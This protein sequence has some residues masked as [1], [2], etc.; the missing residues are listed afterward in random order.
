MAGNE[1]PPEKSAGDHI[2]EAAQTVATAAKAAADFAAGNYLGAA[3]EAAKLLP[4]LLKL[5]AVIVGIFFALQLMLCAIIAMMASTG[6]VMKYVYSGY[7]DAELMND[8]EWDITKQY[9]DDF[10]PQIMSMYKKA[11]YKECNRI[12]SF[13]KTNICDNV[14]AAADALFSAAEEGALITDYK[15]D[16]AYK[17]MFGD[18]FNNPLD[19]TDDSYYEIKNAALN[20]TCMYN[21]WNATLDNWDDVYPDDSMLDF[22]KTE[23][24][25]TDVTTLMSW[26]ADTFSSVRAFADLGITV[27]KGLIDANKVTIDQIVDPE[28]Y[29][30]AG[31]PTIRGMRKL[32]KQNTEILFTHTDPAW[33]DIETSLN[34]MTFPEDTESIRDNYDGY[35]VII[36]DKRNKHDLVPDTA[37][38]RILVNIDVVYG[39]ETTFKDEVLQLSDEDFQDAM[40]QAEAYA[41]I[42]AEND[43]DY[44][45]IDDN[46]AGEYAGELAK[47]VDW[48]DISEEEKSERLKVV[49]TALSL[50]NYQPHIPYVLGGKSLS[51]MDCSGF[52]QQCFSRSGLGNLGNANTDSM[53]TGAGGLLVEVGLYGECNALPGDI[54]VI[55]K[56]DR[57]DITSYGHAVLWLGNGTIAESCSKGVI[58]RDIMQSAIG[59]N[60]RK[61]RSVHVMRFVRWTGGEND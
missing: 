25:V 11:Y 34:K 61:G 31:Y 35:Q 19:T 60:I 42:L 5:I 51:G 17:G 32:L 38:V 47:E 14:R 22:D 4:K 13:I 41:M 6:T 7:S 59:T 45:R 56:A 39:G 46:Q 8:S 30:V 20:M 28:F 29:D 24:I 33:S 23:Q 43:D 21:M 57:V 37:S 15:F 27:V 48:E 58:S 40:G 36:A 10:E 12:D 54:I 9:K 52:V 2:K 44:T 1:N 50:V 16:V 26:K 3:K 49:Q 55:G 18:E 53:L